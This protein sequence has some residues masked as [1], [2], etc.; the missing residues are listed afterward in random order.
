MVLREA[1]DLVLEHLHGLDVAVWWVGL[2][3]L[4]HLLE[5][6]VEILEGVRDRVPV[7]DLNVV[8]ELTHRLFQGN[9]RFVLG[10]A[11]DAALLVVRV[12]GEGLNAQRG[13][14]RR[15]LSIPVA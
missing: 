6:L 11:N 4:R 1:L 5:L 7:S 15:D 14:E 10:G 8:F 13:R 9:E 3:T 12:A 2:E